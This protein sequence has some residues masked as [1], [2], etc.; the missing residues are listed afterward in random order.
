M[1]KV[2]LTARGAANLQ[3]ELKQLKTVERPKVIKAIAEAREHGDLK[4]NAEYHAAREQQSF[5][6]GRIKD[7]E[8]K[9]SHAQII[10]VTKLD[11]GGKVVFG[12]TV[13]VLE[14]DN[15]EEFTYQIV[16]DDEADIKHGLISVSSPIARALIGKQEGD[17]VFLNTPGGDREF[18]ILE[19]RYV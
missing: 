2:P 19:V 15:D 17:D 12:A 16:G 7:I 4:E 9:L 11:A 8:G 5:I 3:D 14:L 6:E 18:E 10:D 13:V 1:N